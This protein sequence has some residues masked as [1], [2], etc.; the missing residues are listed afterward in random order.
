MPK[1]TVLQDHTA[2]MSRIW[3]CSLEYTDSL[4]LGYDLLL[5]LRALMT[6]VKFRGKI[7]QLAAAKALADT[8]HPGAEVEQLAIAVAKAV[9]GEIEGWFCIADDE[10]ALHLETIYCGPVIRWNGATW[11]MK[12]KGVEIPEDLEIE[13][14]EAY[15]KPRKPRRKPAGLAREETEGGSVGHL[16]GYPGGS[17]VS[18]AV[19]RGVINPIG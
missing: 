6:V 11:W 17:P 5:Q 3:E 1:V 16:P 7:Y 8:L 2:F 14:H 12:L 4:P 10:G 19:R 9:E 13:F 15:R 18:P